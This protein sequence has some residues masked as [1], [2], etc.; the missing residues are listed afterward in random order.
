[1]QRIPN[2]IPEQDMK[3]LFAALPT[4]RDRTL[5]LLMWISCLRVSE[6]VA[7][8]FS[9]IECSRRSI[10]ITTPKGGH[11]RVVFMDQPTFAVLNK[12]LDEERKNLFP[13]VNE[14]FV[15]FK[16]KA[17]GQP[18]SVNT[19][20]KLLTYYGKKCNLPH[21]HPHLFRHTGITQLV[22]QKMPEPVV[23]K[24][25]GHRH[26][27]SLIPYLHLGDDYVETEFENAQ[28]T[29]SSTNWLQIAL[30]GGAQ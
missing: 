6:V 10:R 25:V 4:W 14:V 18:L 1:V 9:D 22:R 17:R 24:F 21:L 15:A 8:Q 16:G 2:I 12:Y 20:Q 19:V 11:P 7:I 13:E 5:L 23:R 27:D 26:P 3:A 30:P 28:T 29:E